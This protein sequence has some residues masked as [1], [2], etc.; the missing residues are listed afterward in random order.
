MLYIVIV[1]GL[2]IISYLGY[3]NW[4]GRDGEKYLIQ[5]VRMQEKTIATLEEAIELANQNYN[6][7]E[8]GMDEQ[9]DNYE[10]QFLTFEETIQAKDARILELENDVEEHFQRCLPSM[11][12]L[13][14]VA[15][16]T[17]PE[18]A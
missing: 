16:A 8:I 2:L 3:K 12:D 14:W 7:L 9:A 10:Q 5:I 17:A 11:K 6:H 15:L 18:N 1:V 13:R 4:V